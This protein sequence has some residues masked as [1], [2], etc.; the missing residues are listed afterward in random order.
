MVKRGV[1]NDELANRLKAIGVTETK[2][3]V[4]NK[5]SRG[6]FSAAFLNQC[7]YVLGCPTLEVGAPMNAAVGEPSAHK[8]KPKTKSN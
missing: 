7:L 5:I 1:T 4:S 8:K 2:S 3:S 6:T